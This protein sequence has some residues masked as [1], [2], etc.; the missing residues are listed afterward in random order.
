MKI[1]EMTTKDLKYK[2]VNKAVVG[3]EKIDSNFEQ[4]PTMHKN[5]VKQ[6]RMLQRNH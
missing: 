5:A 3:F 2:L 6:L 4:C 1:A